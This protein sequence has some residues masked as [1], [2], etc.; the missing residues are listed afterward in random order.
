MAQNL[1]KPIPNSFDP[2]ER[3]P[4]GLVYTPPHPLHHHKLNYIHQSLCSGTNPHPTVTRPQPLL[5]CEA[6]WP[7]R[8][9]GVRAALRAQLTADGIAERQTDP[10]TPPK[11]TV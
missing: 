7:L 11:N 10:Y 3:N 9:R 1:A 4:A 6:A 5:R 2:G 8:Q